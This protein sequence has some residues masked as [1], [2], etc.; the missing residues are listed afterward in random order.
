MEERKVEMKKPLKKPVKW[1]IALFAAALVIGGGLAAYHLYKRSNLPQNASGQ[2]AM[3]TVA[4]EIG[5]VEVTVSG[6][7]TI[8]AINK[9]TLT[10]EGNA[11]VDEVLADVGDKV[12]EGD[13]LITFENDAI[14][15]ITAPFSGEITS[16]NV[17]EG[18]R[19]NTGSELAE[20]TDY[21]NLEMIVNVDELDISKVKKGQKA[22]IEI[23]AFPDREFSGTV[24]DVAKEANENSSGSVAKFAVH[25]K[26]D[27][28]KGVL[29][30]MTA[31]AVITTDTAKGV[32][33]LPIEAV[34]TDG[35][36]YYV[37]LPADDG[38]DS[39]ETNV[40]YRRQTVE[41]G[42]QNTDKVEIKSG[43]SAGDQV[44]VPVF[45]RNNSG[46]ENV[47]IRSRFPGGEGGFFN[48]GFPGGGRSSSGGMT[49]GGG[50]PGG[51]GQ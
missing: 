39:A 8:S 50:V 9:E 3:Q 18:D 48:G 11:T 41:I 40:S 25:V 6:T 45:E 28:A 5:D 22:K 30:G 43:L 46:E 17:E 20:V 15:P 35:D 44:L 1:A 33:T 7:G 16:L 32:V 47:R 10:A 31:E 38:A 51:Q 26:L 27:D 29:V 13:E 21:N 12:S 42:L 34:Q 2:A 4:A 37:L 49:D 14:D 36:A 24:T 19:V 23:N